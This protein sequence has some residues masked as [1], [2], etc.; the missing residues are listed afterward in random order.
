[1]FSSPVNMFGCIPFFGETIETRQSNRI[2][3][4]DGNWM[5]RASQRH[6]KRC[7]NWLEPTQLVV[8]CCSQILQFTICCLLIH[9]HV[10][11]CISIPN[12]TGTIF[13]MIELSDLGSLLNGKAYP[14]VVCGKIEGLYSV[15]KWSLGSMYVC[16]THHNADIVVA[17]F[18]YNTTYIIMYIYR[19][20]FI[21]ICVKYINIYIYVY[22]YMYMYIC[23]YIYIYVYIHRHMCS[24]YIYIYFLFICICIYMYIYVYIYICIY[25]YVNI[26]IFIYIYISWYWYTCIHAYMR[27][28]IGICAHIFMYIYIYIHTC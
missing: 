21:D 23:L 8:I 4:A 6:P 27:T 28:Y 15:S 26:C 10:A 19:Y 1:M 22:I 7:R 14:Q 2:S 9:I 11:Y 20:I 17:S 3:V 13:S 18:Y 16:I 25:I 5:P 24:V 12:I